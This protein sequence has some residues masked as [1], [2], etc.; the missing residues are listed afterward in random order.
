[1]SKYHAEREFGEDVVQQKLNEFQKMVSKDSTLS[2]KVMN[3]P[4]PVH[5][6]IKIVD[7]ASL[8]SQVSNVDDFKE[9]IKA[10]AKAE[11]RAEIEAEMKDE[12]RKS[13]TPSLNNMASST[14]EKV[15]DTSL[16]SILDGR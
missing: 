12:K 10:E 7:Q 13:V 8:L 5:E 11:L 6:A 4:S 15:P 9:K 1:M 16:Q 2:Q 3:S 14:G